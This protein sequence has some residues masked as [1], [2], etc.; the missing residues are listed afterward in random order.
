M[1]YNYAPPPRRSSGPSIMHLHISAE[2]GQS[3]VVANDLAHKIKHHHP[4]KNPP[5]GGYNFQTYRTLGGTC[6]NAVGWDELVVVR[7]MG[8][9]GAR[10]GNRS[11]KN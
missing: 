5:W 11:Q 4:K 8:G 10:F 3:R 2:S 9:G 7:S 1:S 6:I